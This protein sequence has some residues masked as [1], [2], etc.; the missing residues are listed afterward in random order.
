MFT[1]K[2][3]GD[4]AENAVTNVLLKRGFKLLARNFSVHNVGELDIVMERDFTLYVFE[5]KARK[6]DS[7]YEDPIDAIT[8]A[9]RR[10]IIN[11]TRIFVSKY[12]LYDYN[13]CYFAGLVL[14]NRDGIIQKIKI[15]PFE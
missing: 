1:T 12:R 6:L 15:V 10:K 3:L 2:E 11:T 8:P 4:R 7:G 13:I 5:V 9:K 14:H